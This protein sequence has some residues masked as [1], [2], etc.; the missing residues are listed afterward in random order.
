MNPLIKIAA[1]VAEELNQTNECSDTKN[2]EN[3]VQKRDQDY[4]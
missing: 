1:M 4:L 2:E 3:N